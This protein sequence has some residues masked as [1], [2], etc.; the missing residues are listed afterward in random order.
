ME[1]RSRRP[2]VRR[3]GLPAAGE[4]FVDAPVEYQA[5]WIIGD[6]PALG[7][8]EI[9]GDR[10]ADKRIGR[11]PFGPVLRPQVSQK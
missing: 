9:N 5:G 7:R 11:N 4:G 10:I 6:F 2:K 8:I 3:R 1:Y